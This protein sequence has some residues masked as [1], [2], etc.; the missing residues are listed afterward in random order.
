MW[1]KSQQ[2]FAGTFSLKKFQKRAI[3]MYRIKVN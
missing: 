3:K 2:K 1:N